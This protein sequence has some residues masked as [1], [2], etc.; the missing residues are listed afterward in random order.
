MTGFMAESLSL[1]M[2]MGGLGLFLDPG[3]LPLGFFEVSGVDPNS[4][5]QM[6]VVMVFLGLDDDDERGPVAVAERVGM[7]RGLCSEDS[8]SEV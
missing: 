4:V 7:L 1:V 5:A 3:G 8:S 6:L 2:T